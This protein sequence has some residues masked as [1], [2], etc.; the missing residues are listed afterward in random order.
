MTTG[1]SMSVG[2][3]SNKIPRS[4]LGLQATAP[5]QAMH[6]MAKHR[7]HVRGVLVAVRNVLFTRVSPSG[8]KDSSLNETSVQVENESSQI[9]RKELDFRDGSFTDGFSRHPRLVDVRFAPN[10][11]TP[12]ISRVPRMLRNALAGR[13]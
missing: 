12:E 5:V 9:V 4:V 7:P 1:A 6:Q 10:D 13:C 8:R 2:T 11:D 3:F